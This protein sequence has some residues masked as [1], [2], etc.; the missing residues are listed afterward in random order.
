MKFQTL[1]S[2]PRAPTLMYLTS[3][4]ILVDFKFYSEIQPAGNFL[5]LHRV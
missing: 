4:N 5:Q 2:D 1:I 3:Y